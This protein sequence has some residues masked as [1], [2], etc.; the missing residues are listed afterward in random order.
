MA[1]VGGNSDVKVRN[2]A[3]CTFSPVTGQP[4]FVLDLCDLRTVASC[5]QRRMRDAGQ[6]QSLAMLL[7][8]Y[9]G[10]TE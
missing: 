10:L 3:N 1:A 2:C 8:G 6:R 9:H 7:T 4:V 5:G